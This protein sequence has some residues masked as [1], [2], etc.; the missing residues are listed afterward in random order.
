MSPAPT[1]VI[2]E[3]AKA[4]KFCQRRSIS[5]PCIPAASINTG[6]VTAGTSSRMAF[7]WDTG[8]EGGAMRTSVT[9]N[10]QLKAAPKATSSPT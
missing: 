9:A 10:A 1:P 6:V 3:A 2:T 4:A 8:M 5:S 7:I